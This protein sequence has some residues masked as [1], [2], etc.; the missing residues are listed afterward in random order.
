MGGFP[1]S[2]PAKGSR[3]L[4]V[5]SVLNGYYAGGYFSIR[6]QGLEFFWQRAYESRGD[7]SSVVQSEKGS[8]VGK[9]NK[10]REITKGEN[11]LLNATLVC[12]RLRGTY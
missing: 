6:D 4:F 9:R 3:V 1:V 2:L 10:M 12:L 11:N 8:P 5:I 7:L